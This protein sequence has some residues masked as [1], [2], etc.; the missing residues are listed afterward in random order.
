MLFFVKGAERVHESLQNRP[1][2]LNHNY[3]DINATT[4]GFIGHIGFYRLLYTPYSNARSRTAPEHYRSSELNT[5]TVIYRIQHFVLLIYL[6]YDD[7]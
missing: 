2:G 5:F 4:R 6:S 7:S 3:S 1:R